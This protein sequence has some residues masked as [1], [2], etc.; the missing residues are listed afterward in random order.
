M[1]V[2]MCAWES[3]MSKG[4]YMGMRACACVRASIG[5][6]EC[7]RESAERSA[8]FNMTYDSY[9]SLGAKFIWKETSL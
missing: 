6:R 4:N 8:I 3:A 1:S 7:D 2:S 9:E 5:V